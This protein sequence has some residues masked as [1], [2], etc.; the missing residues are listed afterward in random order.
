MDSSF[1]C[2]SGS[3]REATETARVTP[4]SEP[5]AVASGQGVN[6]SC[7][8]SVTAI[9]DRNTRPGKVESLAG[10]YRYGF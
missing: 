6:R 2:N 9:S 3:R 8:T 5:E 1:N 7:I 10:R 4:E